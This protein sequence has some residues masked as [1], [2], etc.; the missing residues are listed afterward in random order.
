MCTQLVSSRELAEIRGVPPAAVLS[1]LQCA[2]GVPIVGGESLPVFFLQSNDALTETSS[3]HIEAMLGARNAASIDVVDITAVFLQ[4]RGWYDT[5]CLSRAISQQANGEQSFADCLCGPRSW[6]RSTI[7]LHILFRKD[8]HRPIQ[9]RLCS[10][11]LGS[12]RSCPYVVPQSP[13]S[14]TSWQSEGWLAGCTMADFLE[15]RLGRFSQIM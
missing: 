9:G 13:S 15:R 11:I 2:L 8:R 14:T 5:G 3:C 7:P 6:K 4:S 12:C 10:A 1:T